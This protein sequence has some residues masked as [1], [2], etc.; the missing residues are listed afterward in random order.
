MTSLNLWKFTRSKHHNYL[1]GEI[2]AVIRN[3]ILLCNQFNAILTCMSCIV[4]VDFQ[5]QNEIY[6]CNVFTPYIRYYCCWSN[7][8]FY[9]NIGYFGRKILV[10][11]SVIFVDPFWWLHIILLLDIIWLLHLRHNHQPSAHRLFILFAPYSFF[12]VMHLSNFPRF[13]KR[14][15]TRSER[16]IITF[17]WLW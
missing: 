10:K 7:I 8:C 2:K 11:C 13:Y 1:N 17:E 16:K 3:H 5:W 12:L 9:L 6:I 4:V 15:N 14:S